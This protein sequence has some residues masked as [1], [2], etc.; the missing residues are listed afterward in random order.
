MSMNTKA[1]SGSRHGFERTAYTV[2]ANISM[3]IGFGLFSRRRC[4]QRQAGECVPVCCGAW[5]VICV[6]S[7]RFLGPAA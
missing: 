3:A 1:K 6:L 5:R 2:L 7:L 4:D